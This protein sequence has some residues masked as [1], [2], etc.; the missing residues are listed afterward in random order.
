MMKAADW[1]VCQPV[2]PNGTLD[3]FRVEH[4]VLPR[5]DQKAG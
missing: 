2:N 1:R 5:K 3:E 4:Q